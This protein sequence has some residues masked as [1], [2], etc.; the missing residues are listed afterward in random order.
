MVY[1]LLYEIKYLKTFILW[2]EKVEISCRSRNFVF[3][4]SLAIYLSKTICNNQ[5]Q[6]YIKSRR[7]I[8][9]YATAKHLD[10]I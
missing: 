3:Y 7:S 8:K 10:S 9:T 4:L 2:Q 5:S 1:N 6:Q